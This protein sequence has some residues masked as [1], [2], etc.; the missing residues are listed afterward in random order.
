[1]K[2]LIVFIAVVAVCVLCVRLV[3]TVFH[4]DQALTARQY[5]GIAQAIC[6]FRAQHGLLPESLEEL[7][8]DHLPASQTRTSAFYSDGDLA[9]HAGLPH[10]YVSYSFGGAREGWEST[11]SHRA[12]E[13]GR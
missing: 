8:P 2:R 3:P 7:V 4:V 13:R 1:M 5:Q 11:G 10:T 9:I 6:N 12:H